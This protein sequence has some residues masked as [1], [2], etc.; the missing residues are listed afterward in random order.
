[1]WVER[2]WQENVDGKRIGDGRRDARTLECA[3]ASYH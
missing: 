3:N 2:R 1:M